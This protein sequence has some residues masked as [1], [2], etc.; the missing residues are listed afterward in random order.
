MVR[1]HVLAISFV[2]VKPNTLK[3][4]EQV[5]KYSIALVLVG[6]VTSLLASVMLWLHVDNIVVF[7]SDEQATD[8]YMIMD[9]VSKLCVVT[10]FYASLRDNDLLK[11]LVFIVGLF[12]FGEVMD[13][14]FFDP[15]KMQLNEILLILIALIYIAIYGR[16][17]LHTE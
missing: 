5:R 3:K 17:T 4:M 2:V 1:A 10:A 14:L 15:C 12:A 11:R 9:H 13:E 8:F 7:T 16:K 6:I